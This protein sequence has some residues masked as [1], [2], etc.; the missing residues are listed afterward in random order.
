MDKLPG[1]LFVVDRKERI[2]VK[3]AQIL[4]I[5]IIAIVGTNCDPVNRLYC[6]N[7]DTIRC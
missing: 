6:R 5:P 4:N 7:D 2:A 3:E 1:A